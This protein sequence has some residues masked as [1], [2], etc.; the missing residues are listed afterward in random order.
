MRKRKKSLVFGF[1]IFVLFLGIGYAFLTT[2]LSINGTTDVDA[3]T[4]NVYF[5]NVRVITGSVAS[6]TP[7]IDS[8]KTTVTFHTHLSKPGDFFEFTVDVKND[9]S[10]DAMIETVTK[11][12]NNSTTIPNYLN[13]TVTYLDGVAFEN[14]DLLKA[15]EKEIYR[16]RIEYNTNINPGD[17]PTSAQSLTVSFGTSYVQSDSNAHAVRDVYYYVEHP[18]WN[19]GEAAPSGVTLYDN[20]QDA[21]TA[22]GHSMFLKQFVKNGILVGSSAGL[23][24]HGEIYYLKGGGSTYNFELGRSNPD[25]PYYEENKLLLQTVFGDNICYEDINE[26]DGYIFK[27]YYC[28]YHENSYTLWSDINNSGEVSFDDGTSDCDIGEDGIT[29]CRHG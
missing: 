4:W 15:N 27:N 20:Y 22:H 21:L 2:T 26:I 8:S 5:D 12:I 9:G 14:N 23:E 3:N 16:V 17:L 1:L 19:I 11:T 7:V 24:F 25:S 28:I 6:T 10:I 18:D 13:Y 29:S